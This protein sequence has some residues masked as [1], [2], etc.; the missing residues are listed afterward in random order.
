VVSKSGKAIQS[1]GFRV[2]KVSAS[3][4]FGLV[5]ATQDAVTAAKY[6]RLSPP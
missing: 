5:K 4:S 3:E 6:V 2:S 1:G